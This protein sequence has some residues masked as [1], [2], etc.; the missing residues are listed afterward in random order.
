MAYLA[1]AEKQ[2][3][4]KESQIRVELG[5]MDDL[6]KAA[7]E[8]EEGRKGMYDFFGNVQKAEKSIITLMKQAQ[9]YQFALERNYETFKSARTLV[10]E[11]A[12][13]LGIQISD[14][15]PSFKKAINIGDDID[16]IIDM[17]QKS[18]N[19]MMTAYKAIQK[20]EA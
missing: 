10:E 14:L 1:K 17:F 8:L 18:R 12:R 6:D 7:F 4:E 15:P 11:A 5:A 2:T 13:E 3:E 16:G 9:G 19:H 20:I